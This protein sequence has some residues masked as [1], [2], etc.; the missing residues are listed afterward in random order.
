MAERSVPLELLPEQADAT[1]APA[2]AIVTIRI[3]WLRWPRSG[4]VVAN[5][6]FSASAAPVIGRD[7]P[8]L[9]G[10]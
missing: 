2:N 6:R 9:L 1:S 5:G 8:H 3:E 10:I 7:D 4:H